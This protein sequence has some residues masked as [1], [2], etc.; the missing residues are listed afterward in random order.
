MVVRLLFICSLSPKLGCETVPARGATL[1]NLL[2][3]SYYSVQYWCG[4][5]AL[6]AK[7]LDCAVGCVAF[8]K[9]AAWVGYTFWLHLCH[10]AGFFGY[11]VSFVDN[12][13]NFRSHIGSFVNHIDNFVS[14]IRSFVNN[15]ARF[16][17]HIVSFAALE[18]TIFVLTNATVASATAKGFAILVDNGK[19]CDSDYY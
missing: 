2:V 14:H 18:K 3:Y 11:G 9:C 15:I 1:E 10:L 6:L 17:N 5:A 16:V 8:G 7:A 4:G 13:V 12:I 19:Y